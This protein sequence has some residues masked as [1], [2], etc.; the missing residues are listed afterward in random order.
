[1]LTSMPETVRQ[2]LGELVAR[3]FTSWLEDSLVTQTVNRG[4]WVQTMV[5][6]GTIEHDVTDIKVELRELRREM[7]EARRETSERFDRLSV[8][9]DERFDR[10]GAQ[11]DERLDRM[12]A[13]FNARFDRLQEQMASQMRWSIGLLAIFG[14]IIAILVGIG[15]LAPMFLP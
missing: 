5:R 12:G 15:Q 1:M 11:F 4:E 6:L 14:T 9:F 8:Q 13:D 3:D 10:L 2:A 7:S